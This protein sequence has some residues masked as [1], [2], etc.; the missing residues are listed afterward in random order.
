MGSLGFVPYSRE[1]DPARII[2]HEDVQDTCRELALR[3]IAKRAACGRRGG[4]TGQHLCRVCATGY[5]IKTGC[6]AGTR[7]ISR[8]KGRSAGHGRQSPW[9]ARRTNRTAVEGVLAKFLYPQSV[10]RCLSGTRLCGPASRPEASSSK[11]HS[12]S[13]RAARSASH[14]QVDACQPNRVQRAS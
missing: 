2:R 12:K 4:K 11:C 1:G 6:Q 14:P 7:S 9:V 8:G 10:R 5:C 13:V 3:D